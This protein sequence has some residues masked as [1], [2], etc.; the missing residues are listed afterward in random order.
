MTEY[1]LIA[2]LRET[3]AYISQDFE[4]F[5][6]ITFALIFVSYAVGDKLG[7][8]PRI[9]VAMLYLASIVLIYS[10]YQTFLAQAQHV[11]AQ[12]SQGGSQWPTV[13]LVL[14]SWSRRFIFV[15]GSLAAIFS[16]FWPVVSLTKEQETGSDT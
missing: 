16:L 11:I 14:V 3:S 9:V 4:F 6:T 15:F 1:E 5:I 10:R 2:L 7:K 8:L 13:D 12:L